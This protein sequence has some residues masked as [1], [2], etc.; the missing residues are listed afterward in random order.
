MSALDVLPTSA[1]LAAPD[2]TFSSVDSKLTFLSTSLKF[3]NKSDKKSCLK[4]IN[5]WLDVRLVLMDT[6]DRNASLTRN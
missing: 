6:R 5:Y 4:K 2:E 3:G 1:E